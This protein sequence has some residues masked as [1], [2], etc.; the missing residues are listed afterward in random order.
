[1]RA[2]L[3]S[4]PA[5]NAFAIPGGRVYVFEGLIDTGNMPDALASVMAHGMAHEMWP[6]R[7]SQ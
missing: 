3:I 2:A 7:P 1:V 6:H 5:A 4:L